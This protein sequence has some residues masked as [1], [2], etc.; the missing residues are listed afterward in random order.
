[1]N[2]SIK[3]ELVSGVFYIA[4]AKYS[5]ILVQL[6]ITAILARLLNPSDFGIVAI[7]TVI[8]AFFNILSDI[9]IGPAII[10]NKEL[11]QSDLNSI[12]SFT[13]YFGLISS[14]LFFLFSWSISSYYHNT[15]LRYVCQL[16]SLPIF[17]YC[18]NIVPQN[19]QYKYK[20]FKFTAI[21]TLIAQIIAGTFSVTGAYYGM[22]LYALVMSQII[23]SVV[24]AALYYYREKLHFNIRI[25]HSS[26]KKI[27]AFSIY[28]FLFNLINYFSRNLDK[29]LIGRFIGLSA[30]GFYD[31]SYRLMI[32]PL[33]NITFVITPVMQPIFSSL[34][35]NLYELAEKYKK[36]LQI[37]SYISFPLSVLLFFT[38]KELILL[39]FG[40]QWGEAILPFQILSL[41]VSMQ[42]L[43][44]TSG[45]I[46]QSANATKQLFISGCWCAF[47]MITSF[48]ITIVYWGNIEAVSYG[49]LIA[50]IA[51]TI[52]CFYLLF[53]TLHYPIINILKIFIKPFF[54]SLLLCALLYMLSSLIII[55]NML[56]SLFIKSISSILFTVLIIHIMRDYNVI[57]FFKKTISNK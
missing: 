34:Q 7:A 49:F 39:F 30:L 18:F 38:A 44:S 14:I 42:I 11:T 43:T 28:Q 23:S 36:I 27:M 8:I 3:Q 56:L 48:I 19:L 1:M 9:G 2:S 47:F 16:L 54:V 37:L 52:Q 20:R 33:Q 53:K 31:K 32:L 26:L 15:E 24:I 57:K 6:I 45:S 35:N 5:G 4:L 51:N 50:Q 41:S 10:Q 22:G 13:L 25:N 46:Y 40:N 55:N 21:V 29:L 12:F 17:F